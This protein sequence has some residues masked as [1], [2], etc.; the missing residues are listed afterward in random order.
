MPRENK[1]QSRKRNRLLRA[2]GAVL[3]TFDYLEHKTVKATHVSESGHRYQFK[4]VREK[5]V[6]DLVGQ[7]IEI[8]GY[9]ASREQ[10]ALGC[11]GCP[12]RHIEN[13]E[14]P[15]FAGSARHCELTSLILRSDLPCKCGRGV[16][17]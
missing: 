16:Y 4:R 7:T 5:D 14:L 10:L 1:I 15:S 9:R 3:P 8:G 11:D 2:T 12:R 6:G 17:G 13:S